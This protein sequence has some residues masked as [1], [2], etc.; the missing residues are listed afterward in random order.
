MVRSPQPLRRG[1]KRSASFSG[2]A[3]RARSR[4]VRPWYIG[5]LTKFEAT[6]GR[7]DAVRDLSTTIDRAAR[8][9][10][11]RRYE[12]RYLTCRGTSQFSLAPQAR[13]TRSWNL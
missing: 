3:N 1:P 13:R 8:A 6:N 9:G 12:A 5:E 2:R 11:E 7:H 4:Y 10:T